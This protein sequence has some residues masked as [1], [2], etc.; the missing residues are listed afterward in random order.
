MIIRIDNADCCGP[1]LCVVPARCDGVKRDL[2]STIPVVTTT[3]TTTRPAHLTPHVRCECAVVRFQGGD[4]PND[5]RERRPGGGGGGGGGGEEV[6]AVS[7]A[8]LLL[9]LV[10]LCPRMTTNLVPFLWYPRMVSETRA[11]RVCAT[12]QPHH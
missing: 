1:E 12:A 8:A 2:Q 5:D 7:A 6:H 3:T 9:L 10:L 11:T 4:I